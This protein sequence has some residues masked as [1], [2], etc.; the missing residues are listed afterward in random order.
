MFDTSRHFLPVEL[1]YR[2]IDSMIITKLNVLHWHLTD[3][4]AVP[5]ESKAFPRF[6]EGSFSEYE[7]YT[8]VSFSYCLGGNTVSCKL[9]KGERC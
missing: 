5:I 8:T 2:L 6:W 7:R 9:C 4:E 1:I 3:S